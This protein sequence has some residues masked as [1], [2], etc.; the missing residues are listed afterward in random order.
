MP[1]VLDEGRFDPA[2]Y[3]DEL[4]AAPGNH[5][6]GTRLLFANDRVRVWEVALQPG[7]RGPFHIHTR[8]YF[9]TVVDGGIG[10][11]RSADD[12][13]WRLRR[14]DRGDTLF[15]SHS[16]EDSMIHD[17]ENAGDTPIRFITT[18]LLD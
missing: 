13:K 1:E 8:D 11:Q 15:M 4:A 14:Y 9:W 7:E 3:D 2:E 12:G 16:P 6:V 5:D 18:E 17:F 10:K